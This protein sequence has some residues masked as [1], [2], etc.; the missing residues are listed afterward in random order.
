V[1]LF[2]AQRNAAFGSC[3]RETLRY[4]APTNDEPRDEGWRPLDVAADNPGSRTT[5]VGL[6]ATTGREI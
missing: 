6:C 1:S 4:I 3:M 2:E 5:I